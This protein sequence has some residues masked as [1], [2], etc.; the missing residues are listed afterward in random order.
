V[1]IELPPPPPVALGIGFTLVENTAYEWAI[2]GMDTVDTEIS[3]NNMFLSASRGGLMARVGV[4]FAAEVDDTIDS[5]DL[6][7]QDVELSDGQGWW[8]AVDYR[9]RLWGRGPWSVNLCADGMYRNESYTLSYDAWTSGQVATPDGTNGATRAETVWAYADREEDLTL[10]EASVRAGLDLGVRV[11]ICD[12]YL[13]PRFLFV[14]STDASGALS[15]S[16][17]SRGFDLDRGGTVTLAAGVRIASKALR[18]SVEAEVGDDTALRL[19]VSRE[20]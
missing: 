4:V 2:D 1:P 3:R 19:G 17:A 11:G 20:L 14:G 15:V 12:A 16:D 9:G 13:G 10:A 6:L 7:L 8:A 18:W 5:E